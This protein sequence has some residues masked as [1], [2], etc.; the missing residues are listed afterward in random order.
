MRV[1]KCGCLRNPEEGVIS[2]GVGV[3]GNCEMPD[4]N[5]GNWTWQSTFLT[6]EA[7]FPIGLLLV[8]PELGSPWVV[9]SSV[10]RRRG[11]NICWAPVWGMKLFQTAVPSWSHISCL[12]SEDFGGSP[13]TAIPSAALLRPTFPLFAFLSLSGSN[14]T[15]ISDFN[16]FWEHTELG[17][18]E[19]A[20]S[21][22]GPKLPRAGSRI[23]P[24][25]CY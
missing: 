6:T 1:C 16:R 11:A 14:H 23:L 9:I 19:R 5:A 2:P 3:T 12:I 25:C 13:A 7:S 24:V 15:C 10:L 20:L 17:T 8:R 21:I 4:V 18:W 22:Q